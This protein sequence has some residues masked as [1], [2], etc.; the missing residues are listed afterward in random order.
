MVTGQQSSLEEK[1]KVDFNDIVTSGLAY[2]LLTDIIV[3]S[4]LLL[5]EGENL[6]LFICA[7]SELRRSGH[8][9]ELRGPSDG[10]MSTRLT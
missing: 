7:L 8:S 1:D 5:E 2:K 6:Y 4:T 9:T 10:D 3:D